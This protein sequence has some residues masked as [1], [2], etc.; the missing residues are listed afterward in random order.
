MFQQWLKQLVRIEK[1]LVDEL[2]VFTT[3]TIYK[4]KPVNLKQFLLELKSRNE[5]FTN[6]DSSFKMLVEN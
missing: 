1:Q 6:D 4:A 3:S 5:K 2:E